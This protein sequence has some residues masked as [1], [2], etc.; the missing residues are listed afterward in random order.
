M[1]GRVKKNYSRKKDPER[2]KRKISR[3][4]GGSGGKKNAKHH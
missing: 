3:R 2:E 4:E 1:K